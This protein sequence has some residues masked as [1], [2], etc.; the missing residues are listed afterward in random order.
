M[1]AEQS[2]GGAADVR[3]NERDESDSLHH[4]GVHSGLVIRLHASDH[5]AD[6]TCGPC[7]IC[8]RPAAALAL[9][10]CRFKIPL[11]RHNRQQQNSHQPKNLDDSGFWVPGRFPGVVLVI[12]GVSAL[13]YLSRGVCWR[14]GVVGGL[15]RG[16]LSAPGVVV[17]VAAAVFLAAGGVC[18]LGSCRGR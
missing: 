10:S 7:D 5:L 15:L 17:L 3:R 18:L 13:A 1:F 14:W 2:Q 4:F 9:L 12:L 11:M 16:G 6:H 8:G